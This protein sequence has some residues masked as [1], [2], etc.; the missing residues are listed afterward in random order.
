MNKPC[1][2]DVPPPSRVAQF[3]GPGKKALTTPAEAIPAIS[4]AGNT[5]APRRMGIPPVRQ[6]ARVTW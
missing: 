5:S 2:M 3:K 1:T 6:R 4:C